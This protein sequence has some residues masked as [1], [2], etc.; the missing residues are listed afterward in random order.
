MEI[1][2]TSVKPTID[3]VKENFPDRYFDWF[4]KLPPAS[5]QIIKGSINPAR[6]YPINE[7]T[8]IPTKIAG[9]MFYND[10][11]EAAH[12]I[13]RYSAEK[14]LK[15]IYRIF[16]R[17][18]TPKFIISRAANIFASYFK[19]SKIEVD[20][21]AGNITYVYIYKF[22]S[23]EELMAYRIAGWIQR[24]FEITNCKNVVTNVERTQKNGEDAYKITVS[25]D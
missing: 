6:W 2:G 3:F 21:V 22:S 20:K 7:S 24:A 5:Q 9:E 19:P 10:T 25:W 4:E 17:I 23:D 8:I 13:G 11:K 14:G 18:A 16:V 15:G 1:K 12:E